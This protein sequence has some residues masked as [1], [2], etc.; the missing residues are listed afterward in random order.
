[1]SINPDTNYF[2]EYTRP[3]TS[4]R[5]ESVL[6]RQLQGPQDAYYTNRQEPTVGDLIQS[7]QNLHD[8]TDTRFK[9]LKENLVDQFKA[10]LDGI[11]SELGGIREENE[12]LKEMIRELK[13]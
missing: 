10:E 5:N 1:M 2:A 8:I 9:W 3:F 11:Q 7:L 12:E 6:L 13:K 4:S